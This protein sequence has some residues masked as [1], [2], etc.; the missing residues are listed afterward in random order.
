MVVSCAC[1]KARLLHLAQY[2]V[3]GLLWQLGTMLT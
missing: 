1:V 3:Q 2:K